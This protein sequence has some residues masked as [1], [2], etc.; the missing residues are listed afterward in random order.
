L[1]ATRQFET[2]EEAKTAITAWVKHDNETRPHSGLKYLAP[3]EWRRRQS[4][5]SA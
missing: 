1:R 2:Y 5:L 4:E 3:A